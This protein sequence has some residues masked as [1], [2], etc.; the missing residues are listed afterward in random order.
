MFKPRNTY[1]LA[2]KNVQSQRTQKEKKG[3]KIS[4]LQN[5]QRLVKC[6]IE[7]S[8]NQSHCY[9]ARNFSTNDL[10]LRDCRSKKEENNEIRGSPHRTCMKSNQHTTYANNRRSKGKRE[11][12]KIRM[13]IYIPG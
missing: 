3:G 6:E 5:K 2:Q 1:M 10:K 4:T 11:I 9:T 8:A 13:N 7:I 12:E